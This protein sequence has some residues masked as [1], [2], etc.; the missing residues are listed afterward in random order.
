MG[1]PIVWSRQFTVDNS[2]RSRQC[3]A[4]SGENLREKRSES[5]E[6][7][8]DWGGGVGVKGRPKARAGGFWARVGPSVTAGSCLSL[9]VHG[10]AYARTSMHA[11]MYS[12]AGLVQTHTRSRSDF[13]LAANKGGVHSAGKMARLFVIGAA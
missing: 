9:L 12:L 2:S 10:D 6:W 4:E 13:N 11:C 5:E 1:S 7:Q 3:P 8:S